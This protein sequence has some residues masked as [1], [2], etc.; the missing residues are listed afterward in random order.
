MPKWQAARGTCQNGKVRNF[1]KESQK[2]CLLLQALDDTMERKWLVVLGLG[3]ILEGMNSEKGIY[4]ILFY[5]SRPIFVLPYPP[6]LLP[7][8]VVS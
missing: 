3:R 8:L 4:S 1:V 2:S 5:Y 7:L 6:D